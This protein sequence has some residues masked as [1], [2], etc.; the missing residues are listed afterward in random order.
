MWLLEHLRLTANDD[1]YRRVSPYAV[2]PTRRVRW[3][4]SC[5]R[6]YGSMANH[7]T[8]PKEANCHLDTFKFNMGNLVDSGIPGLLRESSY[9]FYIHSSVEEQVKKPGAG[10]GI[11][12]VYSEI[13]LIAVRSSPCKVR[14]RGTPL[15]I[16]TS[17]PTRRSSVS[18]IATSC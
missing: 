17:S 10:T 6:S 8:P 13:W 3:D 11:G 9:R 16:A 12:T 14:A 4:A 7:P 18:I 5:H 2:K 1:R 15:P